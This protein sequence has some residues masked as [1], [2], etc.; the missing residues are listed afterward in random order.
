VLQRASYGLWSPETLEL[1]LSLNTELAACA[2]T[3]GDPALEFWVQPV[4]VHAFVEHGDLTQARDAADRAHSLARELGQPTLSWF[5]CFNRA[6]LELLN[7]DLAA[8]EQLA[9]QAFQLGQEAGQPDAVLVY[10]GQIAFVRVYQGRA[11]EVVEML[12]QSVSAFAGVAAFRAGLSQVLCWL[13][14]YEEAQ[15]ILELAA[16][17]RFEHVGSRADTLSALSLYADAA[18][19]ASHHRAAGM[20]YERLE[21]FADQVAWNGTTSYGQAR[22][23]LGLL[24]AVLGA[25]EQADQHLTLAC[26]FHE[27]NDLPLWTARGQLG[28]AKALAARGEAA[29]AREHAARALELSREHGYGLFEPRAASLLETASPAGA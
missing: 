11:D 2:A 17:D 21:P 28:W 23:Y 6:T 19:E 4:S 26:E 3:L 13:E 9:E 20:L 22:M 8:G 12:R 27:S 1:R 5:D 15:P 18:F 29:S 7:G 16:S 14:L 10:G 25:H 24:A